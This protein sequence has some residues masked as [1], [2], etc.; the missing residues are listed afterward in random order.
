MSKPSSSK[1]KENYDKMKQN[2]LL[3]SGFIKPY[4]VN[5][6]DENGRI[7]LSHPTIKS[8]LIILI[9]F[10]KAT[11][12]LHKQLTLVRVYVKML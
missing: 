12:T 3:S 7:K 1:K 6:I 10:Q 11:L 9:N 4:V 2:G 8:A 5:K